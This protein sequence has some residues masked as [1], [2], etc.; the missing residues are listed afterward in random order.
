MKKIKFL[1]KAILKMNYKEMFRIARKI[2]KEH[3]KLT[4]ITF[5]DIIWCGLRYGAG[6]M[7]YLEF[8][9]YLL[10]GSQRKT[11]LTRAKNNEIV[12]K[13]NNKE[14]N[15]YLNNKIE[16]NNMFKDYLDRD[17]I[18]VSKCT[19]KEFKQ[20]CKGKKYVIAKEVDN[21]GGV[22]VS[23]EFVQ[24]T[25]RLYEKLRKNKQ[26]LVEEVIVQNS[27][28]SKLYPDSVN[29]LRLFTFLDDKGNVQILNAIFKIGN[30]GFVDNFASGGMYTFLDDNGEVV[31]PAI[32]KKDDKFT[33][34]PE[35]KEQII[36]FKVPNYDKAIELVKKA[37][38]LIPEIR[39]IGW[40]V[41]ITEKG[42]C[43]VEGNEFPGV[44]QI[45]PSFMDEPEGILTRYNKYMK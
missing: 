30:K 23:K 44:F 1:I 14:Y 11:F 35:T 3:G 24:D 17:F 22:G 31:C 37:S 16:F 5:I 20:F 13:Y 7:D 29:T 12:R 40:D 6:Y 39:Y 42:A 27:K 10:N 2:S 4:I 33:I 15:H 26:Y 36:G 21:C 28:I 43:L 9:F 41:A 34:H 45:K 18:D 32:N 25:N 8:E 19:K 38:L